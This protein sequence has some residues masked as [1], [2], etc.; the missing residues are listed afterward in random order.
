MG[1]EL[2]SP[3]DDS[4]AV[5]T[6]IL[7]PPGIDAVELRLA[8]RDRYGITIAGGHGD[9]VDRL[10]RIGH[11]GYVDVF[12]ITTALGAI[13]LQL[14]E[15]G[16]DGR[17]GRGRCRG[18]RRLRDGRSDDA[19]PRPRVDRRRR[20]R[21]APVEV[22]GRRRPGDAA[23]GD[24]R[25]LR[26]DRDPLGDEAHG[27]PDRARHEPED[28]RARR[29]RASTTSTS[30]RRRG[31]A[32]SSRTR[33]SRR[34]SR[35]PSRPS[36]LMVALA[37]NIPQAHAALKQGR[38]ERSKWGGVELQGKTLGV[39]GFGRIGQQVARRAIGLGMQVVAYDPF[40]ADERFR[41]LGVE[42]A[43][44]ED[45]VLAVGRLPHPALAADRRD[46]RDDQP[47]HDREDEGRGADRQRR[48]RGADRRG[49]AGRG[50]HLRQARGRRPRR[51]LDRSRTTGRCSSSTT[52]S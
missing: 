9:V 17:A 30:R 50:A 33:P 38:W 11:I 42:H 52:S 24:H 1:L 16:A 4:A 49:G 7:T 37:R 36:G 41:E 51:L 25:P 34:S 3:D 20:S 48:P 6:G 8:L 26:R 28:D 15:M 13:E 27:R 10:F 47:R 29:R 32:S 40:V 46:A 31:A 22:R 23:R 12:D 45:D 44:T 43:P 14:V 21:P 2:Y 35:P 39:L 19:G 18:S 5:L